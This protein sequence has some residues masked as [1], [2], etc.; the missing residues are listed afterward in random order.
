MGKCIALSCLLFI[1]TLALLLGLMYNCE[2]VDSF[3]FNCDECK[4]HCSSENALWFLLIVSLPI[5]LILQY[6]IDGEQS[7]RQP[8]FLKPLYEMAPLNTI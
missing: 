8:R 1:V 4:S 5:I 3:V 6:M 7:S 2:S